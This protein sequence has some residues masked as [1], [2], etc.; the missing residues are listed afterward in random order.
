MGFMDKRSFLSTGIFAVHY[1]LK[2][3]EI[4]SLAGTH[5]SSVC[6]T[7]KTETISCFYVT[8]MGIMR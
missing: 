1:T 2:C 8:V 5:I 7:F 4:F 6:N 3:T